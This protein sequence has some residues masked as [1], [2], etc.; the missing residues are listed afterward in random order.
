MGAN[1]SKRKSFQSITP[2]TVTSTDINK[3]NKLM[4]NSGNLVP[5]SFGNLEKHDEINGKLSEKRTAGLVLKSDLSTVSESGGWSCNLNFGYDLTE[6]QARRQLLAES[7]DECSEIT[8]FLY[9]SGAKVAS[10]RELLEKHEITRI[11]NCSPAV[12]KNM[13]ED[14]P[15]F[16]YMSLNMLDSSQEDLSWFICE[17][18]QFVEIGRLFGTKTLIHCEK[19][20]SRSCSFAIA[21]IM[22]ASSTNWKT[23][24]DYVKERR[25]ICAPNTGFSCNLIEFDDLLHGDGRYV[26]ILFRCASHLPHDPNTPVLKML[27]KPDARQLIQPSTIFLSSDGIFILRPAQGQG[28]SLYIWKG[29][30]ASDKVAQVALELAEGMLGVFTS[31]NR[32]LLVNEGSEPQDFWDN[33]YRGD[34][35]VL[36]NDYIDLFT[37]KNFSTVEAVSNIIR[38]EARRKSR[39]LALERL[40]IATNLSAKIESPEKPETPKQPLIFTPSLQMTKSFVANSKNKFILRQTSSVSNDGDQVTTTVPSFPQVSNT[41]NLGLKIEEVTS[42]EVTSPNSVIKEKPELYQ[43]VCSASNE[44]DRFSWQ[45]LKV[46]DDDDM[47]SNSLLFLLGLNGTHFLWV[48][49]NFVKK[50]VGDV[51]DDSD[52]AAIKQWALE[53]VKFQEK[54]RSLDDTS[55]IMIVLQ[56]NETEEWWDLYYQGS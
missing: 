16:T 7:E 3:E 29:L 55:T 56:G 5:L 8:D 18:V 51:A 40:T 26:P 39:A 38:V 36:F 17:V 49:S 4:N 24:F 19:G 10:S 22:W 37:D 33:I 13:F 45:R 15:K 52:D 43:C 44:D 12:V 6:G 48:G 2:I 21:Y 9:I 14:D 28:K 20:V 46:Y 11:V 31:A 42:P 47:E 30:H 35:H 34:E 25:L 1:S 54:A 32:V 53:N 23:A 50:F 27:R 41:I